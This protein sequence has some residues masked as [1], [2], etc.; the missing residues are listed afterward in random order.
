MDDDL[1]FYNRVRSTYVRKI[2]HKG[3]VS[4][5]G[6]I[7]LVGHKITKLP[8]W[9]FLWLF[10]LGMVPNVRNGLVLQFGFFTK[11]LVFV[12]IGGMEGLRG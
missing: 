6:K 9:A 3:S 2:S 1:R 7:L 5:N 12:K 11:H 10:P 8:L 4:P